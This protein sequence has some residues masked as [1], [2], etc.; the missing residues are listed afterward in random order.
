M[1]S[2]LTSEDA[3][4]IDKKTIDSGHNSEEDLI[5]NAGRSIAQFILENIEDPFNKNFKILA[6]PGNNGNDAI[7]AHYYLIKY[8][9]KSTLILL[10]NKSNGWVLKKYNIPKHTIKQYRRFKINK[11]NWYIDGI[12]GLGLNKEINGIYQEAIEQL[13][14]TKKVISIDIPSGINSNNG[15]SIS[16]SVKSNY[17]L[18]MGN[19]KI[20]HYFN[21]GLNSTG[22]L[23]ILDI[24][25][26]KDINLNNK[27]NLIELSDVQGL[28]PSI[29]KNVHKYIKGHVVSIA[30]SKGYTGAAI[31]ACISALKVGA[32]VIKVIV[33]DSLNHIFENVLLECITYP[34]DDQGKGFFSLKNKNELISLTRNK[35]ALLFGP[36]LAA[37]QNNIWMSK[38]LSNVDIPVVLDASGFSPIYSKQIEISQLP[39]KCILTPHLGEFSKIFEIN[40]KSF[41]L[42]P[43]ETIKSIIPKLEKRILI[44]KGPVIIIITS[45]GQIFFVN[46]GN[47]LLATSGSGDVLAGILTGLIAQGINLDTASILGSY[48][49]GLISQIYEKDINKYGMISSDLI[50]LLPSAIS[51]LV[52]VP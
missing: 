33:P 12:F 14:K 42:N 44:V 21:D 27:F 23:I 1:I 35:D 34:I 16:K 8:K 51:K 30:G 13:R 11:S 2:I 15:K 36:G 7:V 47:N 5:N 45:K 9:V 40:L 18:A 17:T 31:L 43:M 26:A 20:G 37:S 41:Y 10:R 22:K 48:L 6:G 24:G 38:V 4:L 50:K 46:N 52:N 39:K 28:Y 3:Q 32:G 29:N 49:H 19:P 25:L